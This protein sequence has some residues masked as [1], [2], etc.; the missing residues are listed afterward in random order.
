MKSIYQI[1]LVT[2]EGVVKT[3]DR[4]LIDSGAKFGRNGKPVNKEAKILM[5]FATHYAGEGGQ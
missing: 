2:E 3:S 4:E 1:F 5:D